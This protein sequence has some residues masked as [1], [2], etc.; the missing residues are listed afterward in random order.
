MYRF[1]CVCVH[2]AYVSVCVCVCRF[3]CVCARTHLPSRMD[4]NSIHSLVCVVAIMKVTKRF[5]VTPPPPPPKH[6]HTPLH[7]TQTVD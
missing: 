2:S 1:M 7:P 6:T 4:I 5:L 3:V